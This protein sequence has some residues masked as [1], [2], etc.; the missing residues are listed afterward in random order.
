MTTGDRW[1][2]VLALAE[3]RHG[4]VA[5][6]D[7]IRLGLTRD[8]I[9][10]RVDVRWLHPIHRGVYAVGRPALTQRGRWLAATLAVGS[11]SVLSHRAAAVLRELVAGSPRQTDVTMPGPGRRHQKGIRVHRSTV[12]TD[13]HIEVVDGIRV[14]SVAW[15]L[16]DLSLTLTLEPLRRAV[17]QAD[18]SGQLNILGVSQLLD[19]PRGQRRGGRLARIMEDYG[20]APLIRSALER[21]FLRLI[22]Q[23][24]LPMP[25]VNTRVAGLEVDIYWP[26]WR[27]VVELDGQK[28]HSDP[29]SF[30]TDR[31]R[32][33][34]LQ[35]ARCRVLRVTDKRLKRSAQAVIDDVLALSALAA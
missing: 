23:A 35:R 26:E 32:D 17:E 8:E 20:G 13:Q 28:F 5:Y 34:R 30:E 18:R 29:R 21:R 1:R 2:R 9:R 11:D 27:L 14:T 6:A 31:V 33:A 22:E 12:L 24:G 16:V 15:T 19:T 7:L 4:V 3:R 10:Y 25:L